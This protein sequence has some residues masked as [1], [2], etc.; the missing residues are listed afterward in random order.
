MR[1]SD[2]PR[3][4]LNGRRVLTRGSGCEWNAIVFRRY[5]DGK[6]QALTFPDKGSERQV[7]RI[8]GWFCCSKSRSRLFT[9]DFPTWIMCLI[10]NTTF[11][12]FLP[13][14]SLQ[15]FHVGMFIQWSKGMNGGC[16]VAALLQNISHI[17]IHMYDSPK[18]TKLVSANVCVSW[19][20]SQSLLENLET[21]TTM[22]QGNF[23]SLCSKIRLCIFVCRS[24]V[25]LISLQPR[26][27]RRL[28][29]AGSFL[30]SVGLAEQSVSARLFASPHAP[31]RAAWTFSSLV[32]SSN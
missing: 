14:L 24:A 25:C 9:S 30:P 20:N 1:T 3:P 5:K 17:D 12:T 2:Q 26:R 32:T 27:L 6:R 23:L 15:P 7:K 22:H 18:R 21:F 19:K 10:L 11:L 16:S 29:P 31:R 13:V 4:P 8:F 28:R